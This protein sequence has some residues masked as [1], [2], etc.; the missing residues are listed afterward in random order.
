MVKNL[1]CQSKKFIGILSWKPSTFT[2][3]LP[4]SRLGQ[5]IHIR[6]IIP[7]VPM[8]NVTETSRTV[9]ERLKGDTLNKNTCV[10]Q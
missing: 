5:K 10:G 1:I 3:I 2:S 4:I 7:S 6:K 9:E 8:G